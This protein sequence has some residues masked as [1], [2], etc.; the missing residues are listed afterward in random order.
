MKLPRKIFSTMITGF[1]LSSAVNAG[2]KQGENVMSANGNN[3]TFQSVSDG[4]N[5]NLSSADT[6]TYGKGYVPA[7]GGGGAFPP[8]PSFAS[9]DVFCVLGFCLATN[10]K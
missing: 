8:D 1:F 9:K 3:R 7:G 5:S 2:E 6:I 4:R 10:Q